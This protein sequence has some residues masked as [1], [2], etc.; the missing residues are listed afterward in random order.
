[1]NDSD[2]QVF[3]PNSCRRK[4]GDLARDC[5]RSIPDL[6]PC[7][8]CEDRCEV[9]KAYV[10]ISARQG[11]FAGAA[12]EQATLFEPVRISTEGLD[13]QKSRWATSSDPAAKKIHVEGPSS[14]AGEI[15]PPAIPSP[16]P[17]PEPRRKLS[18][19]EIR[20]RLL[21]LESKYK[22]WLEIAKPLLTEDELSSFLQSS[23]AEKDRFILEF[24]K[25]HS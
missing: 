4:F 18:A 17:T 23:A 12:I 9:Y 14:A 6:G 21:R 13:R 8:E 3:Y 20:E 24:W 7:V 16:T 15:S 5:P 19:E 11:S 10:E 2:T 22:D 1:M 25:R